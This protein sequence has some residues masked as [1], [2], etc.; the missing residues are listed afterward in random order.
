MDKKIDTV[1][2]PCGHLV[3][4][5]TCT[6][7]MRPNECPICRKKLPPNTVDVL[8]ADA[9]TLYV[10]A[11]TGKLSG[12]RQKALMEEAEAKLRELIALGAIVGGKAWLD[13]DLNTPATLQAGKLYV[14]F[15][16]EPMRDVKLRASY[17]HTI[18]RADYGSLQGGRT[19]DQLFRIANGTGGQGNPG[20]LPYKSK[21]IDLSAEWYYG[22]SS[23]VSVGYFHKDVS[24]FIGSDRFD[25][26]AF[27]LTNPGQGPRADA[28]RAALGP[29]ATSTDIRNYIAANFTEGVFTNDQ[30]QLIIQG[31]PEDDPL[32]F[33]ITQ[34]V[35]SD[36]T[37]AL[38]GWEFAVQHSFWDTGFGVILNY[39]IVNGDAVYDNTQPASVT[40]FALTGLSDS[41]NAVAFYDKGPIQARVAYN[42]RDKFLQGSGPNP[43]YIEAYG[44]VDASASYEFMPGLTVFGEAI[45]LTGASRRGHTRSDAY[46]TFISPGFAR[47][48]A[49]VRYAF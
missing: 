28:A 5:S 36:Q 44:Q 29:T 9:H 18:T 46:V 43:T 39:T 45:N 47:Y 8:V 11:D 1:L 37:A 12:A 25:T 26:T 4:C 16:I 23:Y 13:P 7:A 42:W 40:Q 31:L 15:D 27:G 20:L 30:G 35:N 3:I 38:H 14:D 33:Q 6:K 10:R 34:P 17:S 24:N 49:G 48:S 22:P 41:A 19:L 2:V 21:N 32:N